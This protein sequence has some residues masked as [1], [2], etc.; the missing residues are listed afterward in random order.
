MSSKVVPENFGKP[1]VTL[2]RTVWS[3]PQKGGQCSGCA[4]FASHKA[5]VSELTL[6]QVRRSDGSMETY[7]GPKEFGRCQN[8]RIW[9][10]FGKEN[11]PITRSYHYCNYFKEKEDG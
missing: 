8:V 4:Y 11:P 3:S 1:N 10:A 2:G 5:K 7:G 9:A 6:V